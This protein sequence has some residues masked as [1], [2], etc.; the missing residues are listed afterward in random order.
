M[1][2]MS[3]VLFVYLFFALTVSFGAK[4]EQMEAVTVLK[5]NDWGPPGIGIGKIHQKAAEIIKEKTGGRVR[6][7]CYFS[8]SLLKYP[9]TFRG[10]STGVAD[11]SL[12]VPQPIHEVTRILS[13]SFTGLPDMLK[14]AQ[15]YRAMLERHKEFQEEFL[16]SGVKW[17][18]IRAMPPNEFHFVKKVAI[19]APAEMKGMRIIGNPDMDKEFGQVGATVIQLGPP[20]W[21]SSLERGLAHGMSTHYC[22]V[23]EFKLLELLK[24]HTHFAGAAGAAPIGFIVNVKKWDTL[25]P[26]VQKIIVDTFHWANE[27]SL[28][29]DVNLVNTAIAE[30][31]KANHVIKELKPAEIQQWLDWA[32]P[33]TERILANIESKGW[34]AKRIYEDFQAVIK[35]YK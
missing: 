28:K 9:D 31:K 17:I 5:F 30:A 1:K 4:A 16:R 3:M 15:I 18:G 12:Y 21:Y 27:E 32:K 13:M 10:V 23:Y 14:T 29:W 2:K 34:P 7:D 8:Q 20:D 11:I 24:S 33:Y 26:D 35:K 25:P 6:V 19:K 22:A